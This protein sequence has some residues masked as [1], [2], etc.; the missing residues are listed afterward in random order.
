M[1]TPDM[2]ASMPTTKD[3]G[4]PSPPR[5]ED[6]LVY[7]HSRDTLY[8]FSPSTLAVVE[9]GAFTLPGGEQT[10]KILDLAINHDGEMYVTG[11]TT[12]YRV[13]PAT[14]A[15][16]IVGTL[17]LSNSQKVEVTGLAFIPEGVFRTSETL[18]GADNLGRVFEID[19]HD[20]RITALGNYPDDWLSSGDIVSV[21]DLGTYATVKREGSE[22]DTLVRI[23]FDSQ[24]IAGMNVIGS[25]KDGST[26]YAR[27]YGLGYWGAA[28]YGFTA[29]GTLIAIDTDTAK[30][31]VVSVTTG[32][33][34]FWGAGVTTQAPVIL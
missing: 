22:A 14:A 21:E 32:A 5:P 27:I 8:S 15:T 10:E 23:I 3:S 25:I 28:L 13:D 29:D 30:A 4:D 18:I 2:D 33:D 24:G 16:T 9:V 34:E 31:T 12:L 26:G 19:T 7:A 17:D 20:A 1:P 11:A 6:V